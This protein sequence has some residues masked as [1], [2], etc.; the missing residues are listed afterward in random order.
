MKLKYKTNIFISE[1]RK[2][3]LTQPRYQR[4]IKKYLAFIVGVERA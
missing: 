1:L 3:V 4:I 2:A